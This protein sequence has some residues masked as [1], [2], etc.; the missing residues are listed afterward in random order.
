M[1][2]SIQVE[3][4]R[5]KLLLAIRSLM[6]WTL[7]TKCHNYLEQSLRSWWTWH[8]PRWNLLNYV[9]KNGNR[10]SYD[11]TQYI[12]YVRYIGNIGYIKYTQHTSRTKGFLKSQELYLRTVGPYLR[13]FSLYSKSQNIIKVNLLGTYST[14]NIYLRRVYLHYLAQSTHSVV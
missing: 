14:I 7:S 13:Q 8:R 6:L 12:R 11:E 5:R 3:Q 10:R 9:I 1:R 2:I 4:M